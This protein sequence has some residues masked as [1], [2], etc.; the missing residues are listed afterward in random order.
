MFV[1]KLEKRLGIEVYVTRSRGIGGAIKRFSDDFLVEEI[2]RDGTKAEV[3][4]KTEIHAPLE[5]NAQQRFLLCVLTKRGWDNFQAIKAVA[6]KLGVSTQRISIAGIKDAEALT[7]QHITI[8]NINEDDLQ[9]VQVKGLEVRPMRYFH[10]KLSPYYLL[11]NAFTITVRAISHSRTEIERRVLSVIRELQNIGGMPN[12]YGHQR[13]GTIRPI[14]HL[15]GKALVK[16]NF[17]KAAILFLAKPSPNEHPKSREARE[18]LLRTCNF[19]KALKNFP[20]S[21]H[22]ERL[23]LKHLAKKPDDFIGAF[24]KIPAKLRVLFPQAYQA[25]LFNKTLSRRIIQGLPIN[26]AEVGDYVIEVEPS[27]L[28]NP[29]KCHVVSQ[30][31]RNEINEAM[32]SGK[33]LLAL[34]LVGFKQ[35]LSQGEQG[36][37][38][39][40]VLE[41]EGISLENFKIK[42]MLELSLK[43]G[44]RPAL[45]PVK[46]FSLREVSTDET[47]RRK[48]KAVI[49]FMLYRGSY[50]TILLREIMKPRNLIKA[51]F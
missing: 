48:K 50:A 41:E 34:P 20:K 30:E 5:K 8:E 44:V 14:T 38:D 11:G 33:M 15:V 17:R 7:A 22:Y 27:G 23:M 32:K 37:I 19:E 40:T 9:K 21:L 26:R 31:K 51:G 43:G 18:E 3:K 6:R 10:M 35:A 24:R 4:A 2:L 13:F 25:Y 49:S 29:L 28:P 16:G 47:T 46:G 39:K 1:S 45:T 12:F 42:G 36:E